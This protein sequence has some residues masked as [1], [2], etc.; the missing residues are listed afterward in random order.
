MAS[1]IKDSRGRSPYWIAC[2]TD[3]T[4]RRLKKS[5]KLTNK[6]KALEIALSL[7]HGEHIARSGAFTETRLRDLL[8]Q[9]LERVIGRPVQHHTVQTWFDEWCEEK[10]KSRTPATAERYRQV[11]RDFVLSLGPR[12][13]LPLEHMT[14]KDIR[15][16]RDGVL[17]NGVSNASANLAVKIVS[18]AFHK[19]LRHGKLKFNPCRELDT[20]G[21]ESAEREP[22]TREQICKLIQAADGDWRPTIL[23]AFYTGARLSDI[24]NMRW[25]AINFDDRLITFSPRKTKRAKKTLHLPLHPNLELELR[26][27]RGL[28]LA[29]VFPTLAGRRAGG[30]G[31]LSAEF[32]AIM[33]R[34]KIRPQIVR[35]TEGGR[36]NKT[37][38]FHSLRHSFN[39]ALANAGVVRELRQALTGHASEKMN[40]LYTHREVEPLRA[41]IAALPRV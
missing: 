31:G 12:A 38:S 7:E 14:A 18:M 19:A 3:S 20:L 39:S 30:T 15:G 13:R 22:F 24:A 17:K 10:S 2:Y 25:S 23:M 11:A 27:R 1:V 16:Y 37:L 4:G 34:A 40:E 21:E 6:K 33:E 28:P 5:T 36:A 26:K 32:A 29:F 35:H 8:E 9:T 41:A